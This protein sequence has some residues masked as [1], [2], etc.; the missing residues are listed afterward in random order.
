[1]SR[2]APGTCARLRA[3][4]DDVRDNTDEVLHLLNAQTLENLHAGVPAG[5]ERRV[6][7][8]AT[9]TIHHRALDKAHGALKSPSDIAL[10]SLSHVYGLHKKG[11]AQLSPVSVTRQ[12]LAAPCPNPVDP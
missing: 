1:M 4:T 7:H 3:T 11:G 9:D 2:S 8:R 10:L 5:A 6:F 12:R